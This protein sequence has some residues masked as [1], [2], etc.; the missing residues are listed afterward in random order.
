MRS[1]EGAGVIGE[2]VVDLCALEVALRRFLYQVGRAASAATDFQALE[3]GEVFPSNPMTNAD[4]LRRLVEKYNTTVTEASQSS[5]SLDPDLCNLREDL[6]EGRIWVDCVDDDW[7][8]VLRLPLRLVKFSPPANG[9]VTCV[10]DQRIDSDWL[11]GQVACVR[12]ALG[13]VRG[14]SES[15]QPQHNPWQR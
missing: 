11:E 6:Q 5:L 9:L 13:K 10:Y 8:D 12:D 3:V 15:I 1:A 2:I 14:A 4:S 7:S